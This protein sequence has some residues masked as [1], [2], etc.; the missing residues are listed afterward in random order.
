MENDF[1]AKNMTA[2]KI[3]GIE[4]V[5]FNHVLKTMS[6]F[7][8]L[9]DGD[10]DK[11]LEIEYDIAPEKINVAFHIINDKNYDRINRNDKLSNHLEMIGF[12]KYLGIP[13]D[14]MEDLIGKMTN[15]SIIEYVDECKKIT[16]DDNMLFFFENY[17]FWRLN[18]NNEKFAERRLMGTFNLFFEKINVDHFSITF[19]KKVIKSMILSMLPINMSMLHVED[20]PPTVNRCCCYFAC[21]DVYPTILKLTL[22]YIATLGLKVGNLID[23]TETLSD[24]IADNIA[25]FLIFR[26]KIAA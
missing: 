3:N 14:M 24:I 23:D 16:Y 7:E 22:Q 4:Y 19:R 25:E 1:C 15:G 18:S 13:D 17:H 21:G 9:N 26:H 10:G 2:F 5:M 12:M 11:M 8:A 6:I 20:V